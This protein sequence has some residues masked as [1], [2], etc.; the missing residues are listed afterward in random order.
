MVS[1]VVVSK[2]LIVI[3]AN[4]VTFES[5]LRKLSWPSGCAVPPVGQSIRYERISNR[6][7]PGAV[8]SGILSILALSVWSYPGAPAAM[9]WHR[10][11]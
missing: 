10:T 5:S 1:T 6:A 7:T 3:R 9:C 4:V 2:S 11:Q 8:H